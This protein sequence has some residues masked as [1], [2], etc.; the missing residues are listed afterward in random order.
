MSTLISKEY[1]ADLLISRHISQ[2]AAK[3]LILANKELIKTEK[4]QTSNLIAFRCKILDN[5]LPTRSLLN[6]RYPSLY[7]T[8]LCPACNLIEENLEHITKCDTLKTHNSD[9]I[10]FLN[11]FLTKNNIKSKFN[12]KD[13]HSL[14]TASSSHLSSIPPKYQT[15]I[16]NL[17]LKNFFTNVWTLRSNIANNAINGIKWSPV[18]PKINNNNPN[19][20]NNST[21]NKNHNNS[22]NSQSLNITSIIAT[23][24]KNTFMATN[25]NITL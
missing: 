12:I 23:Q 5:T 18:T 19:K 13:L 9:I 21:K 16:L 4:Y 25:I 11:T 22:P 20:N 6:N 3:S 7:P 17:T 10:D 14:L 1:E 8:N 24:I 2:L 15:Q